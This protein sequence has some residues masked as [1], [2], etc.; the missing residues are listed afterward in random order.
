MKL[1]VFVSEEN[2]KTIKAFTIMEAFEMAKK[3]FKYEPF[4]FVSNSDFAE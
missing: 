3:F 2:V 1:F 4:Q